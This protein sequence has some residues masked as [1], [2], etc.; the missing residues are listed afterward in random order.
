M[1]EEF[2]R[3]D[4]HDIE[5][6][7]LDERIDAAVLRMEARSETTLARMEASLEEQKAQNAAFREYVSNELSDMRKEMLKNHGSLAADMKQLRGEMSALS[8][9][10][11]NISRNVALIMTLFGI[12][13][14]AVTILIQFIR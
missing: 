6:R 7:R 1:N 14:S 2:V 9:K 11:D 4:I 10:V 12:A 3:K 5:G 13:I 8:A